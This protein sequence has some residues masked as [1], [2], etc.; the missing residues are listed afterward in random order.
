VENETQSDTNV[1]ERP[2][3]S[4]PL[5]ERRRLARFVRPRRHTRHPAGCAERAVDESPREYT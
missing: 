5:A 2:G 3:E 4:S 1:T